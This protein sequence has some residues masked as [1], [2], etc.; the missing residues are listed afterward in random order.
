[1]ARNYEFWH[2]IC[3]IYTI[4]SKFIS[5]KRPE[6]LTKKRNLIQCKTKTVALTGGRVETRDIIEN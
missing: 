6:P 2:S 1:M 5:K 4:E 3:T